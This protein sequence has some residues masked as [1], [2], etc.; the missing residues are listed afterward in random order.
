MSTESAAENRP[1]PGAAV[2][3]PTIEPSDL[4][5]IYTN[6]AR[7]TGSPE[8]LILDFGL[9]TAPVGDPGNPVPVKIDQRLVMNYYTAMRWGYTRGPSLKRHETNFGKIEVDIAKRLVGQ[10]GGPR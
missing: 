8:E 7:V 6:F 5:P 2:V 1:V 9:N 4:E 3:Q 10:H